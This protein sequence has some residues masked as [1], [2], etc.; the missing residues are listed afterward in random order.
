MDDC[1]I[2][3]ACRA[4][5]A[6][7]TF[8]PPV[9]IGDP[10]IEY[11]DGALGRNNPIRAVVDEAK[12]VWPSREF[13][14]ILSI[15]TGIPSSVDV[16]RTIKPLMETLKSISTEAEETAREFGTEMEHQLGI[17]Q[18]VYFRFNVQHGLEK[19]AL[20]EWKKLEEIRIATR[21]YLN[22]VLS[23]LVKCVS[24]LHDPITSKF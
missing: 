17:N 16:G 7:P 9:L 5:T 22:S 14:C 21:V 15:G 12:K 3:Q 11:V 6:A 24:R 18:D 2:W 13:G 1:A 23:S 19:V 8:F 10:P 4:T 20:Q